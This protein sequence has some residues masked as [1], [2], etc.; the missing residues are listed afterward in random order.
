M[1]VSTRT[2]YL[3]TAECHKNRPVW[4]QGPIGQSRLSM[5]FAFVLLTAFGLRAQDR[6]SQMA[7]VGFDFSFPRTEGSSS[8]LSAP[9]SSAD[10][11]NELTLKLRTD[12][13]LKSLIEPEALI[14]PPQGAA[15][16]QAVDTPP[17][18]GQGGLGYGRRLA[19]GFATE[20]IG[21]TIKFGVA[22]ADHEDPRFYHS[23]LHGFRA[24]ARFAVVHTFV[25][26]TDGGGQ[27]LALSRLAGVYGA[28]FISNA[29][30]PTG[31][32]NF[33]RGSRGSTTLAVDVEFTCYVSSRPIL[34]DDLSLV[35][36]ERSRSGRIGRASRDIRGSDPRSISAAPFPAAA[37]FR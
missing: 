7:F 14:R 26:S 20:L 8:L 37:H 18:W 5:G 33:A 4:R 1:F 13:Y 34:R 36:S 19:S 24:R 17:Q 11:D 32:N 35:S 6:S 29:W 27:V 21:R 3:G 12:I 15:W 9:S 2:P 25:S 23:Q 22:A 31:Y 28:A 16:D 10:D 30:Y